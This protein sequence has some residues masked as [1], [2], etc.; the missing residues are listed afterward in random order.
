MRQKTVR[1]RGML[2]VH[3]LVIETFQNIDKEATV[4]PEQNIVGFFTFI[5]L[6]NKM[7][8]VL[9]ID[10]IFGKMT[11]ASYP[12]MFPV[13]HVYYPN[14]LLIFTYIQTIEYIKLLN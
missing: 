5:R 1:C 6:L 11:N 10:M 2:A 9:C 13:T 14:I 4:I 3:T 7:L 8:M 12:L